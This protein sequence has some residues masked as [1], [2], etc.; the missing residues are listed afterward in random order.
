MMVEF[1]FGKS[2]H[3]GKLKVGT[4]VRYASNGFTEDDVES[5]GHIVSFRKKLFE[6]TLEL[7]VQFSN[8][9]EPELI[10]PRYL[11]IYLD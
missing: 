7:M 5:Y 6:N 8:D 9:Q 3:I 10:P 2:V 1:K 4:V 11:E